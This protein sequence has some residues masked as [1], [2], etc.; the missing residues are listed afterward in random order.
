M[1]GIRSDRPSV[2]ISPRS[3]CPC[4]GSPRSRRCSGVIPLVMNRS[5]RRRSSARMPRAAYLDPDQLADTVDDELE[6][7][8]D[9]Q[10]AS[11]AADRIA[12]R[13]DGWSTGRVR[14][15][16]SDPGADVAHQQEGTKRYAAGSGQ[17]ARA[18][19]GRRSLSA[20]TVSTPH[21]AD[22][23]GV[24]PR[25]EPSRRLFRRSGASYSRRTCP[26]RVGW[27][28]SGPSNWPGATMLPCSSS[29]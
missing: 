11:D 9:R 10:D 21:S 18:I 22:D 5:I 20:A 23:R 27:R 29:A 16:D 1:S 6:D 8:F 7:I 13:L 15:R 24:L 14:C 19:R 3:P 2:M 25:S 17:P 12:Q 4:G 26:P 28:P